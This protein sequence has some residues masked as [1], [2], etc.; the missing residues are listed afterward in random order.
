M[1]LQNFNETEKIRAELLRRELEDV[2]KRR[3]MME[4]DIK[5]HSLHRKANIVTIIC[6][7]VT[8]IANI[9]LIGTIIAILVR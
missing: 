7:V 1:D 9:L 3:E 4:Y 5:T 6:S 8:A 2:D